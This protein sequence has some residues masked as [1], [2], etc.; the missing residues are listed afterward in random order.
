MAVCEVREIHEDRRI[1]KCQELERVLGG[2]TAFGETAV[3]LGYGGLMPRPQGKFKPIG[4]VKN[5]V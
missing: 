2:G 3:K 4:P 5:S 1:T